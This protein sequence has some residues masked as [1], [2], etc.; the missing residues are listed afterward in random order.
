M[1]IQSK[2]NET[3]VNQHLTLTWI[4]AHVCI[5]TAR[6]QLTVK[7]TKTKIFCGSLQNSCI[8][9][10]LRDFLY[11]VLNH[12][13][14]YCRE[15]PRMVL[16]K[17]KVQNLY[18][19]ITRICYRVRTSK[20]SALVLGF[21]VFLGGRVQQLKNAYICLFGRTWC[22]SQMTARLLILDTAHLTTQRTGFSCC[23]RRDEQHREQLADIVRWSI[24]SIKT[25]AKW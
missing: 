7:T 18:T 1:Q 19:I 4:Q 15:R 10:K 23:K 6:D 22:F 21:F 5:I 2:I 9:T 11:V 24:T 16:L 13:N 14:Q 8:T 20:L 25:H 17:R 12:P 3:N